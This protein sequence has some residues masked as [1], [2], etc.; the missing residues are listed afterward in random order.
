VAPRGQRIGRP[1]VSRIPTHIGSG[2]DEVARPMSSKCAIPRTS[3]S[4]RVSW[5]S[6]RCATTNPRPDADKVESA[7]KTMARATPHAKPCLPDPHPRGPS[8]PTTH[9]TSTPSPEPSPQQPRRCPAPASVA[10]LGQHRTLRRSESRHR[11]QTS[12]EISAQAAHPMIPFVSRL[13]QPLPVT[14]LRAG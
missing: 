9:R 1:M 3:P 8:I 7:G 5:A 4:T 2:V 13:V 10:T 12:H 11:S 6:W 14:G